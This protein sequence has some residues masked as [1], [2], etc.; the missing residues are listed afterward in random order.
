MN[1][2]EDENGNCLVCEDIAC[3]CSC[4]R[5]GK[6]RADKAEVEVER[7][8]KMLRWNE[9]CEKCGEDLHDTCECKK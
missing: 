3:P 2:F 5:C 4:P 7:L 6:S 9:I 8:R 1:R